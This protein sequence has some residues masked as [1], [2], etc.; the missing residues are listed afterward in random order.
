MKLDKEKFLKTE[1]GVELKNCIKVWDNAIEEKRKV[2]SICSNVADEG[3]GY[4]YWKDTCM[5]CQAQWEVYKMVLIQFYGIEY[6]FTRT[7]DY[8]GVVTED[9]KNWL[10]K[11]NRE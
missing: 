4:Q 5:C 2:T 6:Y 9:E 11:I 8:F 3:L 1:V 7:D 10:F